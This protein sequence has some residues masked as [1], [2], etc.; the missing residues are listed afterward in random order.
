VILAPAMTKETPLKEIGIR[1]IFIKRNVP[2]LIKRKSSKS[3]VLKA[4]RNKK[5]SEIDK[6]KNV[7]VN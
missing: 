3:K 2:N 7:S 5:H 4:N 6:L 1:S